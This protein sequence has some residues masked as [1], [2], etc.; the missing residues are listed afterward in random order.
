MTPSRRRSRWEFSSPKEGNT[1]VPSALQERDAIL[2]VLG[3]VSDVPGVVSDVPGVVE[4][5]FFPAFFPLDFFPDPAFF[6]PSRLVSLAE[7]AFATRSSAA[8]VGVESFMM[9]VYFY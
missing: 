2:D 8:I 7:A 5:S 3:V 4:V 6:P 9:K 1:D